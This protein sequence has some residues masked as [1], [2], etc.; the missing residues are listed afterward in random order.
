MPDKHYRECLSYIAV[1]N[2]EGTIA[3]IISRLVN[4]VLPSAWREMLSENHNAPR[5]DLAQGLIFYR[6]QESEIYILWFLSS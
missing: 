5:K 1:E 6:C 2:P 3:L 4:K